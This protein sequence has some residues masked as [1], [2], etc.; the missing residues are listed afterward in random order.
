MRNKNILFIVAFWCCQWSAAY[1]QQSISIA[2]QDWNLWL[3]T[4]AEWKNDDLYLPGTF[5][6]DTM[7]V[8]APTCGWAALNQQKDAAQ[9]DLPT[10][11]EQHFWG[12]FGLKDYEDAYGFETEDKQVRDGRY[13][14]VSW[15]SKSIFI[16][17]NAKGKQLI[18]NIRGARLR[19]EVYL[20]QQLVGYNII[21]E[22]SF[23]C[24]LTKAMKPGKDNQL[25]IRITNP[26]GQMD[27]IDPVYLQWGKYSFHRSHGFGGLDRGMNI[28]I[29]DTDLQMQ[30]LYVL[31]TVELNKVNLYAKLHNATAKPVKGTI[32]Y[33]IFDQKGKTVKHFKGKQITLDANKTVTVQEPCQVENAKIWTLEN[34]NLYQ[35]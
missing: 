12:K 5:L 3:D 14:G 15:W 22:T 19:A 13:L 25:A 11:V 27:W 4:A 30:D 32:E 29:H 35:V 28:E 2:D 7:K 1:A 33:T 26:G 8:N 24:D 9:V 23:Q 20:N 17:K 18:L 6:V 34:P 31:N 16:P 10:T 21:S